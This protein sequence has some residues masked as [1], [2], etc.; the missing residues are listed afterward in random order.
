MK[1][2]KHAIFLYFVLSCLAGLMAACRSNTISAQVPFEIS[3][4]KSQE[5]Q[6]SA[7]SI[8]PKQSG[9]GTGSL[10][11]RGQSRTYLLHTPKSYKV[12][13]PMP[14]VLAFHGYGSQG[15]DLAQATGLSDVAEEQGFLVA[16]P[17]GLDRR[18]NVATGL[19]AS[20]T[21]D[22]A[23]VNALIQQLA[24]IRTVDPKRIYAV[25]VSNG[26]FLVQQ[27]ACQSSGSIAAFATVAS[28][29]LEPLQSSCHPAR[30]VSILMINGTSDQKVPWDGGDRPYGELLAVPATIQFWREHNQC[31]EQPQIR[32]NPNQR[33]AIDRY[34]S[35]QNGAEVELVSLKGVGHLWPRGGSGA[36]QLI[37]G[38]QES[39]NF[40]QRHHR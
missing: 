4:R 40:F 15:K 30:P 8:P 34:V 33:V 5:A 12:G 19:G 2:L 22:M 37:N 1:S 10:L 24:K 26:G 14:L 9:D 7:L 17:D 28:T 25:G 11:V 29:L 38:S 21:D 3:N 6:F 16:Y 32:L 31:R 35:C 18:W 23:F 13:Q 27:L 20:E 39:W 36:N